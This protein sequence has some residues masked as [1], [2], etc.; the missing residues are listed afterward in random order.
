METG[1]SI[2]YSIVGLVAGL[3]ILYK[4][5]FFSLNH[6]KMIFILIILGIV[7]Y[8]TYLWKKNKDDLT[9]WQGKEYE[10]ISPFSFSDN[11][12]DELKIDNDDLPF[13]RIKAFNSGSIVGNEQKENFPIMYSAQPADNEVAL[14]EYG[15]LVTT[16]EVVVKQQI[17]KEK[18][19]QNNEKYDV[20]EQF[21]PFYGIYKTI[22]NNKKLIIKYAN[23]KDVT[24]KLAK[25]DL[26]V[27]ER[28][29]GEAIDSGWT[30]NCDTVMTNLYSEELQ[31]AEDSLENID[32]YMHDINTGVDDYLKK[33]NL[34]AENGNIS[35]NIAAAGLAPKMNSEI[36]INQINDRF[37]GGQGHG[38]VGEQFGDTLDSLKGKNTERLGGNH[39]KY[40]AD[41]VVNQKNIQT[42]FNKTAGK[43]VGQMFDTNAHMAKYLNSDGTMMMVEVPKDQYADA[44]RAMQKR[45]KSGQVP[46]E[47]NPQ[48]AAKYVKKG[49]VTYE[50][51]V[52]ATKSIFDRPS[53]TKIRIEEN[54]KTIM[55]ET[56][57]GERLVYS[58]GGDFLTGVKASVPTALVTATWIY[59]NNRWQGVEQEEAT[60]N[61][62]IGL[63]QPILV[64]GTM[65]MVA[66]QF[67]GATWVRQLAG[68]VKPDVIAK[69][70]MGVMTAAIVIGPDLID[71]LRGRISMQQLVKNTAVA[72][73]GMAIGATVGSVV[74]VVGT[75]VGGAIGSM[76]AKMILDNFL[77]DDRLA[78]SRVM[79]E[80]FIEVV[81][82]VPLDREEFNDIQK[83]IFDG[84]NAS[85]LFKE[86][87]ASKKPRVYIHELLVN[88]VIEKFKNREIPE[89]EV[90]NAMKNHEGLFV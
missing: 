20:S 1:K 30:K 63:A 54:G 83:I 18:S 17:N 2:L 7:I 80:E 42:K 45:I 3:Y 32:N 62:L 86:M 71:S 64:G 12:I 75:V 57:F 11:I 36:K 46:Q 73:A 72:G 65:Y 69:R 15:Y 14:R 60:K 5:F 56:T 67:G 34:Q 6:I 76:G 47:T 8:Q 21:I 49:A 81:M 10:P 31:S 23:K 66:S 88:T 68:E 22:R 79:K 50:H 19:E 38:H 48:N 4:L 39:E 74:P 84:K 37:G 29:F 27:L 89:D 13:N 61:A 26:I 52:I 51:S 70:T 28:V 41:R 85:N 55:H 59:C 24:I 25:D 78:M 44:V 77:E 82:F 43:S 35:K 33:S 58:A 87:F 53:D 40:G 90:I 9:M 16:V